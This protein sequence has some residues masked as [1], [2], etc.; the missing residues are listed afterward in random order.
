[1]CLIN[2]STRLTAFASFGS[3]PL[4]TRLKLSSSAHEK[5]LQELCKDRT[6]NS[7]AMVIDDNDEGLSRREGS[8]C[9]QTLAGEQHVSKGIPKRN[10]VLWGLWVRP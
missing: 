1:M 2:R 3:V 9:S 7:I 5:R 6:V 10:Y 4:S 8:A